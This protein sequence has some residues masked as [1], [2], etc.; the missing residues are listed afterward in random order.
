LKQ[1]FNLEEILK[2]HGFLKPSSFW[3]YNQDGGGTWLSSTQAKWVYII[4]ECDE[5][6]WC[7]SSTKEHGCHRT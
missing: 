2:D 1:S 3:T 7:S 6:W 5:G 4:K